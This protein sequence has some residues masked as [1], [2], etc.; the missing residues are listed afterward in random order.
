MAVWRSPIFFARRL[1]RWE[2]NT[3][4]APLRNLTLTPIPLLD[5]LQTLQHVGDE[6]VELRRFLDA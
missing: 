6:A 5:I 4:H 2:I 3:H 1:P